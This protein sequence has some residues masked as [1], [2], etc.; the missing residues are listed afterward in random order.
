MRLT[1]KGPLNRVLAEYFGGDRLLLHCGRISFIH[2][3]TQKRLTIDDQ[4]SGLMRQVIERL[5]WGNYLHASYSRDWH[6]FDYSDLLV[7]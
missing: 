7:K 2:P 6:L 1:G 5:E 4:P 3:R